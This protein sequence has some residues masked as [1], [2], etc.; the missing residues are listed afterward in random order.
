MAARNYPLAAGAIF[1][2]DRGSNYT[3]LQFALT[4]K[5]HN[6][7][8]SVGRTGICERRHTIRPASPML[9]Q[10]RANPSGTKPGPYFSPGET[11]IVLS[12]LIL[13]G[14][15]LPAIFVKPAQPAAGPASRKEIQ[16]RRQ[17]C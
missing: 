2:S 10:Q 8:Q 6:L 13:A 15:S 14:A 9:I 1:H 5:K 7:R 11:E 3:S 17:R 12:S 16:L 4:L